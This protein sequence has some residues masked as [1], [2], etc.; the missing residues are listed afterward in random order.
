MES[1]QAAVPA[2]VHR[3]GFLVA[4]KRPTFR[5]RG[6]VISD[7]AGGR[8]IGKT[9]GQ[10]GRPFPTRSESSVAKGS[11]QTEL[12]HDPYPKISHFRLRSVSAQQ[13]SVILDVEDLIPGT[14]RVHAGRSVRRGMDR[15]LKKPADF[16]RF[17]GGGWQR[18]R[19]AS[20]W[21]E[22]KFFEGT[23]GRIC[24]REKSAWS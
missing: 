3:Q 20:R 6:A 16:E 9:Q 18:F 7:T 1:R 4:A 8:S 5:S 24:G 19:P 2:G 15:A 22:M 11:G 12:V 14:S 23:A 17:H 13:L 10:G 21:A